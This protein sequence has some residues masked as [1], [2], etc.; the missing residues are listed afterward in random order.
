MCIRDSLYTINDNDDPPVLMFDSETY[1][2]E[3]AAGNYLDVKV[4]FV[5]NG[6]NIILTEKAIT[7]LISDKGTGDATSVH[8]Y[9]AIT[10][11]TQLTVTDGVNGSAFNGVTIVQDNRFENA[12]TIILGLTVNGASNASAGSAAQTTATITINADDD[13]VP[14]IQFYSSDGSA[15]A[16]EEDVNETVGGFDVTFGISNGVITDRDI[17]IDYSIDLVNSTATIDDNETGFL[18]STNNSYPSDFR[19]WT[20]ITASNWNA[21]RT[22]QGQITMSADLARAVTPPQTSS[23]TIPINAGDGVDENDDE[24]LSLIH[25]SEPTRP[26]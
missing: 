9:S 8:D 7:A 20:G 17:V 12:E 1:S 3:E 15:A 23:F 5:D 4:K 2:L 24:T 19:G 14:Q 26:Y 18:A 22:L 21:D 6:S 13:D 25:I 10:S 11:E 16:N